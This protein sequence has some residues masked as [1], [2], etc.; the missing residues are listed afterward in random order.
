MVPAKSI[1]GF[2]EIRR[3]PIPPSLLAPSRRN[4]KP[5][6]GIRGV[7]PHPPWPPLRKGGKRKVPA[8]PNCKR[9]TK[10]R[11]LQRSVHASQ[12]R[13][14]TTSGRARRAD[15]GANTGREAV[16][17]PIYRGRPVDVS[18]TGLRF[19]FRKPCPGMPAP[20]MSSSS[21]DAS[22]RITR[23]HPKCRPPPGPRARTCSFLPAFSDRRHRNA[24]RAV[25][26]KVRSAGDPRHR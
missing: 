3:L 12:H 10:R 22:R 1:T 17:L 21:G 7:R 11:D 2:S 15:E 13:R 8:S 6:H 23:T 26:S 25:H 18:I 4:R 5:I 20:R 24:P 16:R 9:A 14:Y 19:F